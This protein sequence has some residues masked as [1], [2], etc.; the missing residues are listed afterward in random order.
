[1]EEVDLQ[2]KGIAIDNIIFN[3]YISNA[4]NEAYYLKN[5]INS[6]TTIV[7]Q[8]PEKLLEDNKP[9]LYKIDSKLDHI[10]N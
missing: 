7:L 3:Q 9:K 5:N 6:S 2:P 10:K 8:L 4:R 1:M